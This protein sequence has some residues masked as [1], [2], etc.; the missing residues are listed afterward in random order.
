MGGCISTV[1]A[2]ARPPPTARAAA[3]PRPPRPV[4]KKEFTRATVGKLFAVGGALAPFGVIHNKEKD[5]ERLLV[6]RET[7]S[8]ERGDRVIRF[9]ANEG[10]ASGTYMVEII[11]SA[12]YPSNPK[13]YVTERVLKEALRYHFEANAKL[14]RD[15]YPMLYQQELVHHENIVKIIDDFGPQGC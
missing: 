5:L 4:S 7:I 13:Q 8:D 15:H 1:D 10:A 6:K 9:V 11:N 12:K 2:P 14:M 3:V